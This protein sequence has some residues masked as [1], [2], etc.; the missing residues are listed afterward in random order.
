MSAVR[1]QAINKP[2]PSLVN[3]FNT[4]IPSQYDGLPAADVAF[5]DS[6]KGL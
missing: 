6:R 1:E 4:F 2:A 5:K 3:L